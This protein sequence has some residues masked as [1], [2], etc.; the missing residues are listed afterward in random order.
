KVSDP[1]FNASH[2]LKSSFPFQ[3]LLT[4]VS[5]SLAAPYVVL[6]DAALVYPQY[7]P[8]E[9]SMQM[10]T[11]SSQTMN[12]RLPSSID[13]LAN[14]IIT[15][16]SFPSNVASSSDRINYQTSFTAPSQSS[17]LSNTQFQV[18]SFPTHQTGIPVV[19]TGFEV[20]NAIGECVEPDVIRDL[21]VFKEPP[22]PVEEQETG[23]VPNPKV[24]LN[25]VVIRTDEDD[26]PQDPIIIPPPEEKTL[27]LVLSKKNEN[28]PQKIIEVP[29]PEGQQPEVFFIDYNEGDNTLLPGD[30]Y[31]QDAL[32]FSE[33]FGTDNTYNSNY[34]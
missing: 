30:I 23:P 9:F 13:P 4:L 14:V 1:S 26:T 8:S 31:L 6:R 27:V 10:E 28:G 19:C 3:I 29:A 5:S 32:K 21:F 12:T 11:S 20:L 18:N 15:T 24:K 7:D 16:S 33:E 2:K 25:L 22:K 34:N 17:G